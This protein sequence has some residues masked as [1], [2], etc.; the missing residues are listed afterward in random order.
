MLAQFLQ[1]PRL[2]HWEAA[3]RVV[4]YLKGHPSRG[5]LLHADS[6]YGSQD[7]MILI[8]LGAR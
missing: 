2:E 3:L 4:R 6:I 8:G 7:G 1:Q 5:I